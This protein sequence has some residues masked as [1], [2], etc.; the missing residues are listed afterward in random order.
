MVLEGKVAIITGAAKRVGRAI[1][2]ALAERGAELVVHYHESARE[3]QALLAE[4]KRA[5]GKPLAVRADLADP[6]AVAEI[7]GAA[8]QAFGRVDILINSA[9]VFFRTPL[10]EL[11][12]G[13]WERTLAVNLTAPFFLARAVGL[14]MREQGRGKIVNLVDVGATRVWADY[15]PYCVSKAGLI[16]ATRG[17]A[18]ALAPTVQV[19]AIAPGVVLLPDGFLTEE[20]ERSLARIPLRRF[21]TPTEVAHTAVYL[22]ENDFVTGEVVTLDGGQSL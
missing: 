7:V 9:A 2:L 19:N 1:A 15:L 5:G 12:V 11:T 14:M 18:K 13:D 10:A 17:L 6:A 20:R 3:A 21:G 8:R 16:A 22:L 4:A